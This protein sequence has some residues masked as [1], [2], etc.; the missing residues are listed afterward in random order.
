MWLDGIFG[1]KWVGRGGGG[2]GGGNRGSKRGWEIESGLTVSLTRER[3]EV[4]RG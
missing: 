2:L 1:L 4:D 3:D